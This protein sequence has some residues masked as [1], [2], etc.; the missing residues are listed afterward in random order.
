[1]T[2]LYDV[3][4]VSQH[5]TAQELRRAY[6]DRAR[7]LHPDLNPS[8]EAEEAIRR[9]NEAWKVLGD[10]VA[11]RSYDAMLDSGATP[12]IRS[13]PVLPRRPAPLSLAERVLRP[14]VIVLAVL[15]MIFVVTAYAGPHSTDDKPVTRTPTSSVRTSPELT[16]SPPISSLV[17][18]CLLIQPGYD[19]VTSC[20]QPN[21][22]QV[23]AEVAQVSQC[24]PGSAGYQLTGRAQLVCLAP[25]AGAR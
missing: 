15:G 17:G 9:L 19:A 1:M 23:V 14:S 20:S 5:A 3:I 13:G 25:G 11:R 16:D 21:N 22:G 24:P 12:V 18:K 4:G 8:A 10:P 7:Q 2:T 6:R